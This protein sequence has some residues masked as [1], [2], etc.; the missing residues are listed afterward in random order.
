MSSPGIEH[1]T[2]II[3]RGSEGGRSEGG[4][5]GGVREVGGVRRKE[6]CQGDELGK[7]Q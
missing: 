2:L 5:G 7:G 4:R 3:R 6:R 1:E